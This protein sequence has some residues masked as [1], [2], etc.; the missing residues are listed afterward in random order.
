MST[1]RLEE[2][3]ADKRERVLAAAL[4]LFAEKGFDG[5]AV[6]EIAREAGVGAGTIYRY[7]ESKEVLVN[8]LYQREKL[9]AMDEA[10]KGFPTD[11]PARAQFAHLF[12]KAIDY[13]LKHKD[14]VCFMEHHHH[15]GYLDAESLALEARTMELAES[16]LRVSAERQVTKD[17]EPQVIISV[18]WG[19][20]ARLLRQVWD[21]HL[22]LTE[23]I[24]AQLE[25]VLW[26]AVR[27]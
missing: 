12:R 15:G 23:E 5:T 21:G 27:V 18:V 7:F 6:P 2:R 26:Q 3:M 11:V 14:S 13:A 8:A 1:T 10:M 16:F 19:G 20:V 4:R 17:V 9:A 24:L 22:E 25:N